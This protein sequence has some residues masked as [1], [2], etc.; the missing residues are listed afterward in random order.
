MPEV[1]R[2]KLK[3]LLR[4]FL[5]LTFGASLLFTFTGFLGSH[6]H[7][8][9][10]TSHF[11]VQY[12]LIQLLGLIW[13]CRHPALRGA[14]VTFITL[15]TLLLNSWQVWQYASPRSY[16]SSGR[17]GHW[18]TLL[19]VN[20]LVYNKHYQAV[21]DVI[22]RSHA[23]VVSLQEIN[24][25]WY[26]HLKEM[27]I[28]RTYP[29]RLLHLNGGNVLLS[30]KPLIHSKLVHFPED[31]MGKVLYR[32]EGGYFLTH[33]QLGNRTVSLINLHPPVP[34][35]PT[36]AESYRHYLNLLASER[37]NLTPSVILF[38]DLNTTP[39]SYYY[40]EYLRILHLKDAKAHHYMPTWPIYMPWFFIPIDHVLVSPDI[41]T[42]SQSVGPFDG[43]D[44]LP[45]IITLWIP[46]KR[47]SPSDDN[48]SHRTG[49]KQ[50]RGRSGSG[51]S[52][53]VLKRPE[54]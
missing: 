53:R 28:F 22:S 1:A 34:L 14:M 36:H 5:K 46:D 7:W 12:A 39:W 26:Q 8:M 52:V 50:M 48:Q 16:D 24:A 2:R 13:L 45:V 11:R 27:P 47:K 18:L 30:R 9:D 3:S 15:V 42:L 37:A 23:D 41:R 44:H 40:R 51:L 31:T 20:V 4:A 17:T 10:L 49:W 54:F 21:Q 32:N 25:R 33:L 19:Q 29:Y 38:G 43:S 6:S 35:K